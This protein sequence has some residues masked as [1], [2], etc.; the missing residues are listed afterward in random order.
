MKKKR[1]LAALFAPAIAVTALVIGATSAFAD[2][3]KPADETPAFEESEEPRGKF[4]GGKKA[5]GEDFRSKFDALT[6]EQKQEIYD[7]EAQKSEIDKQIA[8]MLKEFGVIDGESGA[9]PFGGFPGM[10]KGGRGRRAVPPSGE[11]PSGEIPSEEF[12]EV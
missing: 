4:G 3:E 1:G 12:P 10:G 9:P 8:D 6:D 11:T 7:L 2:S 5:D